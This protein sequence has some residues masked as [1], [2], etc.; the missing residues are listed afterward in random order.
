M[1]LER[2]I[3]GKV[4]QIG[5][6]TPVYYLKLIEIYQNLTQLCIPLI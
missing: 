2:T 4:M 6:N 3:T 1:F 5:S